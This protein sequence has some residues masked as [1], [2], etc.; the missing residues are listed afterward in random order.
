VS[1]GV[2]SGGKDFLPE[3]GA[4]PG[5][6]AAASEDQEQGDVMEHGAGDFT[7]EELQE[8][9]EGDGLEVGADPVFKERL[10]RRLWRLVRDRLGLLPEND[11]LD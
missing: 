7:I 4:R 11:E 2:K 5:A 10:R 3:R 6:D 9:L 1:K 8:F